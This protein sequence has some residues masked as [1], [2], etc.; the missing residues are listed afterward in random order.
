MTLHG[1]I[2]KDATSD[3]MQFV[4]SVPPRIKFYYRL[5]AVDA[6]GNSSAASDLV[7]GQAYQSPP[8]RPTL[9][10]PVWDAT[11]RKV[12]LTW[13]ASN[14]TLESRLERRLHGGA[15]WVA[16]SG[17]LTP[18]HYTHE[19]EPPTATAEVFHYRVTTRDDLGQVSVPSAPEVTP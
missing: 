14:P 3:A 15:I 2:G 10:P 8:E 6:S 5:V 11:H 1:Q 4:D 7:A 9:A 12:T 18:G 13:S 16:A 17:W 19:D